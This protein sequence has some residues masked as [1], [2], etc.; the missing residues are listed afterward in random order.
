ML[1]CFVH[2]PQQ[3]AA[4]ESC[5]LSSRINRDLSHSRKIDHQAIAGAEAREAVSSTS[6]GSHESDLASSL[7]GM[8]NVAHTGAARNQGGLPAKHAI[9]HRTRSFVDVVTGTQQVAFEF[10]EQR[11]VRLLADNRHL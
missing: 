8:L 3:T 6:N 5:P 4:A 9:P 1:R 10:S 7:D 2:R 11:R